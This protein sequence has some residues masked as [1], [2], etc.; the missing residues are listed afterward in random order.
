MATT[1]KPIV[2]D[3]KKPLSKA[4][5]AK[6]ASALAIWRASLTDE[7]RAELK[8]RTAAT[9]RARWDNM[10]E[11]ERKAQLAGVKAWQAHQRAAKRAAAKASRKAPVMASATKAPS[12]GSRAVSV[13][14]TPARKAAAK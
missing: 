13:G 5:R 2:P 1:A 6:P 9:H 14:S 11:K 8:A 4:H 10:T 12:K 3:K 7:D